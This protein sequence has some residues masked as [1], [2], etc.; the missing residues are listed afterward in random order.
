VEAYPDVAKQLRDDYYAVAG[1]GGQEVEQQV[2]VPIEIVN[3]WNPAPAESS[4]VSLS[5]SLER[6][7]GFRRPIR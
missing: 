1:A 5:G 4:L 2:S 3:E 7:H 6:K